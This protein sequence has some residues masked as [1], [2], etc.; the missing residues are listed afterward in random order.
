MNTSN[1]KNWFLAIGIGIIFVLF[2]FYGVQTF[3]PGPEYEDFCGERPFFPVNKEVCEPLDVDPVFQEQC[4]SSGGMLDYEYD[5]EG[6]QQSV[7]CNTCS[8]DFDTQRDN[9][10][11]NIFFIF[12][13]VGIAVLIGGMFVAEVSVSSGLLL[14]GI[15]TIIIGTLRSWSEIGDILRFLLL[16]LVLVLLIFIGMRKNPLQRNKSK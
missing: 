6:C 14:G 9:Y 8:A 13:I 10:N 4:F 5:A 3:Y 16:G 7:S 12:V 11:K 15:L 2:V 1:I